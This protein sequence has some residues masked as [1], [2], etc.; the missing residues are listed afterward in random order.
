MIYDDVIKIR[1]PYRGGNNR[2]FI[3][4]VY[5]NYSK[6]KSYPRYIM[7]KHLDRYLE[8]DEQVDH[9]DGNVLNNDIDNLQ[10]LKFKEH[11][12]LD[13][14][15]N[16][17]VKVICTYCHKKI[18]IKGSMLHNR[19]RKDRHQSGY[20]CS[21]TCSGKY[22]REIQLG[23]RNCITVDKVIPTKYKV[24]SAQEETLEVEVG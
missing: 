3:V 2:L 18:F 7:E 16:K 23:L 10:I 6:T 24:K 11:Q 9:I 17:D 22:G 4:L 1:G 13:T 15:R 21:R 12:K 19:N 5:K 14:L 20:F 8:D